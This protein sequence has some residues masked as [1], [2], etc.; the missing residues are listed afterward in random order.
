VLVD[1]A[2]HTLNNHLT[3][4][5]MRAAPVQ[6]TWIGYPNTTGLAAM[7][8]RL[9]DA[10]CDPPG[11]ET[12]QSE[13]LIRLPHGF[14]CY[15]PAA[16]APQPGLPPEGL[17]FASFNAVPKISTGVIAAW[18]AILRQL[19]RAGLRL[20][21]PDLGNPLARQRLLQAFA[22]H[23]IGPKQLELL[24]MLAARRDHFAAY[25]GVDVALDTFP[26]NGTTTTCEALWMGVPVLT[27][28]GKAH[29]GRVGASLLHRVGLDEL[30]AD[31][32]DA[33]VERAIALASEKGGRLATWRNELR[34]R[35]TASPLCRPDVFVPVLEQ[36]YRGMATLRRAEIG[37]DNG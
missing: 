25:Q 26:Y 35:M 31:G 20:K 11:D 8:F 5:A 12:L 22:T 18:A 16:E 9:S 30:I 14:L 23:G 37:G 36:A 32:V 19:P 28:R 1:L 33:Y 10:I 7:D 27:L 4:F 29:A 17:T 21:A 13:R 2:G 15:R 6:A 24:P 3:V 34:G